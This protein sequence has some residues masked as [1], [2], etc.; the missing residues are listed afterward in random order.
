MTGFSFWFVLSKSVIISWKGMNTL[1]RCKRVFLYKVSKVKVKVT[2]VHTLRLCT[3]RTAHRGSRVIALPIH[4][5]DT[6]RWWGASLTP[7][8]FFTPEKDPVP[9][10]QEAGWTLGPV[11]TGAENLAPPT[12]QP[13]SQSLY[14]LSYPS[15]VFLYTRNIML[16]FSVKKWLVPRN[17]WRYRR[18]VA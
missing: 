2:P 3:G 7:R 8:P 9:I 18:S 12:V 6:R 11:W 17:V 4:E 14:W 10:V 5:H 15:H 13:R 1:C 16:W